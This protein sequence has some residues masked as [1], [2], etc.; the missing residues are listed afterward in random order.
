MILFFLFWSFPVAFL[1]IYVLLVLGKSGIS[2]V[3]KNFF[4]VSF[5]V[6]FSLVSFHYINEYPLLISLISFSIFIFIG[7]VLFKRFL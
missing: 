4:F 1:F 5:L 7:A 3:I 6:S 2:E